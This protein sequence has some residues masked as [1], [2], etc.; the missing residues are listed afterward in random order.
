MSTTADAALVNSAIADPAPQITPLLPT[1]V[2]LLRGV[3]DASVGVWHTTAVVREMTG[4]DEEKLAE[5]QA[6]KDEELSFGEYMSEILS[7]GVVS[8][9]PYDKPTKEM[10]DGL[11]LGDREL[12]FLAIVRATYGREREFTLKCPKCEKDN[13]V[14]VDLFDD[15]PIK[16]P[17]WDLHAPHEVELRDGS[18]IFIS[19]PTGRVSH[20]LAKAKTLAERNTMLLA[21]CIIDGDMD[22]A[23]KMSLGDRNKVLKVLLENQ[24][25]PSLEEVKA[26][27]GHCDTEIIM[28][29]D[30]ASLL[31]G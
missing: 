19:P 23:R 21:N 16:Q 28:V 6:G 5:T 10:L 25:G 26:P 4:E 1:T 18:V 12:L 14:A 13:F 7:L 27:C 31:L 9:G 17:T 30:W 24:P 20:E 15:F 2:T 29:L 3:S 8:L 11:I 22:M